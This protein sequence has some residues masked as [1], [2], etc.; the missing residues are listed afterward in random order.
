MI[1]QPT[2]SPP[3][4]KAY[5]AA[6]DANARAEREQAQFD[7]DYGTAALAVNRV[8]ADSVGAY[9]QCR[10][11]RCRRTGRCATARGCV[12]RPL[13]RTQ[14]PNAREQQ[15]IDKVYEFIQRQRRREARG[16]AA[17]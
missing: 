15:A 14:P 1:K 12:V 9:R 17:E 6:S 5:L 4:D 10:L 7:R 13:P 8:I 16:E 11:R 3:W 2:A